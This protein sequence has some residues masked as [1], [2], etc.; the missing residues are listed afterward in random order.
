MNHSKLKISGGTF[1][2]AHMLN[3]ESRKYFTRAFCISGTINFWK[4]RHENHIRELQECLQI[5][6]TDHELVDYL[7]TASFTTLAKCHD[8]LWVPSIES[9]NAIQPFMTQTPEEIHMAG[10]TPNMDAMFS[11]TSQVLTPYTNQK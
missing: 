2:H 7:K 3:P 10:K 6:K 5:N 9:P 8:V 1:V 4:I 11:F